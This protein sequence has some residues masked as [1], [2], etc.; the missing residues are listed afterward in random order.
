MKPISIC[1]PEVGRLHT[2]YRI[3]RSVN[4]IG[5]GF[6]TSLGSENYLFSLVEVLLALKTPTRGKFILLSSLSQ[7]VAVEQ[8]LQADP[9]LPE[10]I[11]TVMGHQALA[12]HVSQVEQ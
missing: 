5:V 6:I 10:E 12:C 1:S 2:V 7:Y 11:M 4:F 3:E 8:I 9:G